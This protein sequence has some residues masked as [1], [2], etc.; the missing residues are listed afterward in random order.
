MNNVYAD[1]ILFADFEH[2]L[3][4]LSAEELM[5]TMQAF[6]SKGVVAC[7]K[8]FERAAAEAKISLEEQRLLEDKNRRLREENEKLK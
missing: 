7:Q 1:C 6:L 5:K 2:S 3:E 8:G 4:G